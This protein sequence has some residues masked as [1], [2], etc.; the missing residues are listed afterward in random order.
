MLNMTLNINWAIH[1]RLVWKHSKNYG[2]VVMPIDIPGNT[3][4]VSRLLFRCDNWE[5]IEISKEQ[6]EGDDYVWIKDFLLDVGN[7]NLHAESE[8]LEKYQIEHT[9]HINDDMKNTWIKDKEKL[10]QTS[11]DQQKHNQKFQIDHYKVKTIHCLYLKKKG[12]EY[13]GM[14]V[15]LTTHSR[16]SRWCD[17]CLI[18][19]DSLIDNCQCIACGGIICSKC[20]SCECGGALKNK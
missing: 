12:F 4:E 13:K 1:N 15:Y 5:I 6:W 17:N 10:R 19:L 8:K 7:P 3:G 18:I 11:I 16:V 14:K 20:G 9:L 2:W